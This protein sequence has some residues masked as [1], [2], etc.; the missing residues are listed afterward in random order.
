[1]KYFIRIVIPL[2]DKKCNENYYIIPNRI[3]KNQK[4]TYK[5]S[6]KADFIEALNN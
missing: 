3:F 6:S 2:D 5:K 1:M 4:W